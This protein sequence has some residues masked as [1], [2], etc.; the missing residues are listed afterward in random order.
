MRQMGRNRDLKKHQTRHGQGKDYVELSE[1]RLIFDGL[2]SSQPQHI[3]SM[4]RFWLTIS[5]KLRFGK[6]ELLL[7]KHDIYQS[8]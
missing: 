1:Q 5:F 4:N 6:H 7:S 8:F 2:R 3:N